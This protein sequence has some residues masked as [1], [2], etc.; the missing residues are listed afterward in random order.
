M[1]A[2]ALT[3]ETMVQERLLSLESMQRSNTAQ[4]NELQIIS[5]KQTVL[6]ENLTGRFD[7]QDLILERLQ[8]MA[9]RWHGIVLAA[10]IGGPVLGALVGILVRLVLFGRP[11]TEGTGLV[12]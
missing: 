6:I 7:K 1:P 12:H 8:E 11:L 3:V 10:L 2:N 5:G 4:L 9:A